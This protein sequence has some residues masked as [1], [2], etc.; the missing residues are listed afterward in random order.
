MIRPMSFNIITTIKRV[1]LLDTYPTLT[2]VHIGPTP[3]ELEP[4]VR[5][6]STEVTNSLVGQSATSLNDSN[7]DRF[8]S[9]PAQN[10]SDRRT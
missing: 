4:P 1:T 10:C 5:Y 7:P 9:L 2:Y 3:S 6:L 8:S